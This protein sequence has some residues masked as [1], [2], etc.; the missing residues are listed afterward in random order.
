MANRSSHRTGRK[1]ELLCGYARAVRMDA[2][3]SV[4]NVGGT[5]STDTAGN[6]L[7]PGKAYEQTLQALDIIRIALEALGASMSDVVRTRLYVVDM[8]RNQDE[9]GRAHLETF[10]SILPC[11]TMVGIHSL[12][13]PDMLVE[14]EVE[15]ML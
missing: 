15:A 11:E 2:I 14:I 8:E 5:T 3:Q 6:V 4:I 13:H 1:Y 9:V 7:H 10:E 12:A